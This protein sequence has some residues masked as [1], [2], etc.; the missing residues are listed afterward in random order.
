MAQR[1]GQSREKWKSALMVPT[2][3]L[4][5]AQTLSWKNHPTKYKVDSDIPPISKTFTCRRTRF[6]GRFYRAK[7]QIISDV[8]LWRLPCAKRESRPLTFPDTLAR[9]TGLDL[10]ELL[11]A[12]LDRSLWQ[13]VVKSIST[14]VVWWL[15]IYLSINPAVRSICRLLLAQKG[16]TPTVLFTW[17]PLL[18][19]Y[20]WFLC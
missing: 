7:G 14:V 3:L 18:L 11:Q 20:G 15:S 4:A 17:E 13:D 8:I 6:D 9:D 1:P 5:W 10:N 19:R 16:P 2:C 12:M